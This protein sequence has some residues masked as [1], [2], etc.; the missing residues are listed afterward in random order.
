MKR[1]TLFPVVLVALCFPGAVA[2]QSQ[3]A[4]VVRLVPSTDRLAVAVGQ[5]TPFTVRAVDASG[6]DVDATLRVTGPRDAVRINDG[7]VTGLSQGEYQI[8][9]TL[10]V[11]A[12]SGL[13]PISLSVPIVV[14]WP[15]VEALSI[16]A[17]PGALFVGTTLAHRVMA[18]HA[19][20]SVRPDP[21]ASWASSDIR[22]AAVDAFG[23][24][25]GG[26]PGQVSITASFEGRSEAIEYSVQP[27]PGTALRLS[28]GPSEARTGDVIRLAAIVTDAAGTQRADVPVSWSHSYTATDGMLGVPATGQ[29]GA[30]GAYVADIPGIHTITASAGGLAARHTFLATARDVVQEVEIVGHGLEDWYRTTDLWVFEGVDGRDY[31]ITG[32]KISGGFA[33]FYDVTNPAA[34]TKVDSV[35]VDARTV[36]DV[37]A[38]PDGRYAV[39]SREGSTNRRDGLVIL[40]MADPRHP[41]V[42]ANFE[43]GITGGVHNM[44]AQDDYLYALSNGDKY[45]IVDMTDIYNP[46]YVSEYNHPDSRLHDVWV[47]EGLAYSS[48]W[49]TGV[50]VVDVGDGRWGGSVEKPVFVTSYAT[51]SGQTH[52]AFPYYQEETGKTYLF[53]GDEIMNRRGLAW[54][55]Y[56]GSMGSY[57][58]R[59]D[60]AT[61]TGGIPLVTRGYIQIV[62]FTDPENPEMV[63]RYEVPE[64]G[65]HNMWVEDDKLYQA[66]YE[67]G[68]RVVDVS[69]ELMGNLY[70]QGREV[71]VF[72]SASPVG[73]T[74]NATMVWGAQP[75]KG[76]VFLSDTNSGLWSVKLLPKTRPIS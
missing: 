39:L 12:D 22:V 53:L 21:A 65:T 48:E 29:I 20:G 18:S 63:A 73:Y 25:T 68:L 52:A 43:D 13:Q 64:F 55:G 50:V 60:P 70:T 11:P 59:Y 37:K 57:Q 61:G 58:D 75:H 47:N 49:G 2:A 26:R 35:Q 16:D 4:R 45:V 62:D 34:I 67:G 41:V 17:A 9:A 5:Q 14:S 36:N 74:P 23:N 6:A 7:A 40:D 30:D 72:K 33:F 71:A 76:H 46:R 44:F 1:S 42:A 24:V 66:Y 28:R 27:F 10:V 54:A 69:G 56:P 31:A 38:S 32:S 19:D 8:V 51:P 3:A 15:A